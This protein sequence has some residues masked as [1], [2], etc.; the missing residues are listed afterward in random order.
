MKIISGFV[1]VFVILLSAF[2]P[3]FS[4]LVLT[5]ENGS[6]PMGSVELFLKRNS[7]DYAIA[8]ESTSPWIAD[9]KMFTCLVKQERSWFLF[10]ISQPQAHSSVPGLRVKPIVK[11]L[12]LSRLQADSLLKIIKPEEGMKYSQEE[13]YKLPSKC[14]V[15]YGE[16]KALFFGVSDAATYHL[17]ER[18]ADKVVAISFYA[19][20]VYLEK[21]QELNGQFK[22][23]TGLLNSFEKL[24]LMASEILN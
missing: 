12:K 9:S 21:C 11:Q 17:A 20:Y 22:I 19:P 23:L 14:E 24:N 13:L 15:V 8:A 16:K 6:I 1:Y 4:Q 3:A 18:S 7:F 5:H 10:Q 2:N